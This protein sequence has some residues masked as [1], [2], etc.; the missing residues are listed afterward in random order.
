M[1]GAP[2]RHTL[3]GMR[4]STPLHLV[5][6]ALAVALPLALALGPAVR[7]D[8]ASVTYACGDNLCRV[9]ADGSGDRQITSDGTA[10]DGYHWPSLSRDGTRMAWTRGNG[11]LYLGDGDAHADVGPLTNFAVEAVIRP[12]G[13]QVGILE[14]SVVYGGAYAMIYDAHGAVWSGPRPVDY[15]LGWAADNTHLLLPWQSTS[16]YGV[17]ICVA[18]SDPTGGVMCGQ[19]VA[20]GQG[21][22]LS[23][24]SLSP[25][26]RTLAVTVLSGPYATTGHI[27]LYDYA[28][29]ALLRAV[30][31]GS[32]D[33]LP[34]WSP[35]GSQLAFQ[36][37]TS[38]YVTAA[39]AT[40][41]SERLL[42]A[43]GETPTW[44]P[45]A[46]TPGGQPQA[47]ATPRLSSLSLSPRAF[48]AA[49]HGTSYSTRRTGT[50]VR[51]Q[52]SI[53]AT[54]GFDV[55]RRERGVR[56][57]G[58]CVAPSARVRGPGCTRYRAVGAF[59]RTSS[60]GANRFHFTGRAGGRRLAPGTYR[61]AA[62]AQAA[63][64]RSATAYA[65]FRI[66]R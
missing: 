20:D 26:G 35:D 55:Q 41:G 11:S 46:A 21:A 28:T 59:T 43:G 61:L 57:H 51:Y 62:F 33:S 47:P 56:S 12:D 13:A 14:T 10:T 45:S 6:A 48:P 7:A 25:D 54:V 58:R 9:E 15:A 5:R 34:A 18:V 37:G 53:A 4:R 49:A 38:L 44:G 39:T 19:R 8:A 31:G 60:A 64:L 29:G 27:A 3:S 63:G 36:R 22:N 42:V 23:T 40:P 50:T 65:P 24:P 66:V 2:A 30:T 1:A 17:D 16:S 52:L 32:D